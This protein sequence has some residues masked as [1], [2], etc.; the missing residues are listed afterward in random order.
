[1]VPLSSQSSEYKKIHTRPGSDG[2]EGETDE[3]GWDTRHH[4]LS[5]RV[6]HSI[7]HTLPHLLTRQT[8]KLKILFYETYVPITYLVIFEG[9]SQCMRIPTRVRRSSVGSASAWWPEFNSR[10][11]PSGKFFSHAMSDWERPRRIGKYECIHR[12]MHEQLY[13][14][15]FPGTACTIHTI[16]KI[17]YVWWMSWICTNEVRIV[18]TWSDDLPR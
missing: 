5:H 17:S 12:G 8:N 2:D 6:L 4:Q 14:K 18:T 1:M 13:Q 9:I 16:T 11:F 7:H 10:L 15:K 3:P